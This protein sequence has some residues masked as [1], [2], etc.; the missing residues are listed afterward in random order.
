MAA[1]YADTMGLYIRPNHNEPYAYTDVQAQGRCHAV[2]NE[3][4]MTT[5]WIPVDINYLD[6]KWLHN[7]YTFEQVLRINT[8]EDVLEWMRDHQIQ[9][10]LETGDRPPIHYTGRILFKRQEDAVQFLLRW[11]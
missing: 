1:T 5:D 10:T 3:V 9:W 6:P 2:C 4:V 8:G 7:P 11:S